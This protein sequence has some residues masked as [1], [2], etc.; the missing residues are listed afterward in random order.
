[1]TLRTAVGARP[2]GYI[3]IETLV[4]L[5]VLALVLGT[6]L[7]AVSGSL[8]RQ[9][10]ALETRRALM[11][12][13][14]QMDAVGSA[15]PLA[16]GPTTGVSADIVWRADIDLI[17]APT[18]AGTLARISVSAGPSGRPARVRLSELRMMPPRAA[19][20]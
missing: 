4:A 7:E 16:A 12:V 8:Q 3:L 6:V 13:R 11:V 14:S 17:G 20:K 15:I 9:R 19:A 10:A 2:G 18:R 5:L 1:M